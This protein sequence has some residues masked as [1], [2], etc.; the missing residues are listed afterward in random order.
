MNDILFHGKT[1]ESHVSRLLTNY[2]IITSY[3]PP[4]A[5][6]SW[7]A[8][9]RITSTRCHPSNST[10]PDRRCPH[11]PPQSLPAWDRI[12]EK[13]NAHMF[14]MM[15]MDR[16][17][18]DAYCVWRFPILFGCVK[19]LPPPKK[20]STTHSTR[21]TLAASANCSWTPGYSPTIRITLNYPQ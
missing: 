1:K 13:H 18:F 8:S 9:I 20:N 5:T 14:N 21:A 19:R 15:V 12:M 6:T 4:N 3:C 10:P 11:F 16:E 17:D 2:R 7:K